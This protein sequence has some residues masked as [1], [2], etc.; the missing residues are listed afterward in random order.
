MEWFTF[1]NSSTC[2]TFAKSRRK[3]TFGWLHLLKGTFWFK[4]N[5]L[6]GK[7]FNW[8][9]SYTK[10]LVNSWR[11]WC[12]FSVLAKDLKVVLPGELSPLWICQWHASFVSIHI[13]SSNQGLTQANLGKVAL[14]E[15]KRLKPRFLCLTVSTEI[16]YEVWISRAMKISDMT[17]ICSQ[18]LWE[19]QQQ[20][21]Q[22]YSYHWCWR[23]HSRGV[24]QIPYPRWSRVSHLM[25]ESLSE[26]EP[27]VDLGLDLKSTA[28]ECKA[29]CLGPMQSGL[30]EH[31]ILQRC[32]Q[33]YPK[34]C[35]TSVN[36]LAGTRKSF[37]STLGT[38]ASWC[39]IQCM[40]E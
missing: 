36:G 23:K 9:L 14:N 15:Q 8:V 24:P 19:G 5:F 40:Q 16:W 20:L 17:F 12:R 4:G 27:L 28:L 18:F 1:R 31:A 37:T 30:D 35:Q 3:S 21:L 6:I 34:H 39:S 29:S 22:F 11:P 26:R 33:T 2:H 10:R 38:R 13:L 7:F 32:E 25:P